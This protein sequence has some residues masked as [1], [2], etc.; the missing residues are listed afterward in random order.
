MHPGILRLLRDTV[1]AAR[2]HKIWVGVCGE[3]PS[4]IQGALVLLGLGL[5]E[6]SASPY[7]IPT[8]KKIVRS[9]TYDETR[10]LARKALGMSTA[11]EVREHIERYIHDKRPEL[12][13]FL[14]EA[15][16]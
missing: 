16:S 6:F 11:R 5:D 15:A 12:R 13:E 9:V 4:S 3:M 7:L 14:P 8:I 2:K 10:S 1:A